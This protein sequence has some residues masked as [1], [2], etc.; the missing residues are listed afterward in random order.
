MLAPHHPRAG[1]RGTAD[2]RAYWRMSEF[3]GRFGLDLDHLVPGVLRFERDGS[4]VL[5]LDGPILGPEQPDGSGP[6]RASPGGDPDDVADPVPRHILG[7]L[8]D[9]RPVTLFDAVVEAPSL[10]PSS[11]RPTFHGSM[12]L[13]GAHVCGDRD[14]VAG[15]RWTW[16]LP[17]G[18]ALRREQSSEPVAGSIPGVLE[19]WGSDDRTGLQFSAGRATPLRRLRH[20]VQHSCSQLLGLWSGQDVP[21]VAHTEVRVGNHWCVL[22]SRGSESVP[23]ARSRFL[24]VQ[25]LS[26]AVFAAWIPLAH[27]VD[28]VPFLLTGPT[29]PRQLDAL[30]LATALE[31]LHRRLYLE[32]VRFEGVGQ[33]AVE[34]AARQARQAGVEVLLSEG[35]P[36][37]DKANAVFRETLRHLNQMTYQDRARELLEPV[38]LIVPGLFGPDLVQ[39]IAM[40]TRIRDHQSHHLAIEF[41]EP[42][43]ALYDAAAKSSRWALLL[44]ILL[45][46]N[47][48]YD[49]PSH[50]VQS[51]GFSAALAGIDRTGLWPGFSALAAFRTSV[52]GG[53]GR[54]A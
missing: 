43:T 16:L 50:L 17:V 5:E 25:D 41:D 31:G 14:L 9:G 36:D 10:P 51:P 12:S 28:P 52:R 48:G 42:P 38:R 15:I 26:V 8:A 46:L 1:T 27:I 35:F 45:E 19:G 37:E 32:G 7:S 53:S 40:V 30:V 6:D 49:F 29:G 4:F 20:Q 33:R 11:V 47:P 18:A 13:A 39:W 23:L 54:P 34:R 24:P 21:G 44:R 3:A 22:R 2:R